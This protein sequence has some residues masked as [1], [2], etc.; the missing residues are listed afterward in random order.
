MRRYL[1]LLLAALIAIGLLLLS[2]GGGHP[3]PPYRTLPRPPL[4]ATEKAPPAGCGHTMGSCLPQPKSAP[5]QSSSA[6]S[7]VSLELVSAT[8]STVGPDLSN[9]NPVYGSAWKAI[10]RHSR[11]AYFKSVE[12]AG[13]YDPTAGPMA[14]SAKSAG[15]KTGGYDFLHVCLGSATG[16]AWHFVASLRAQHLLGGANLPPAADAEYP[17]SI[18]CSGRVW[19]QSWVDAV[20]KADG[21]ICPI[22][23]TGAWWWQPH[24]GSWWPTCLNR[25]LKSWISGYG[26]SYPYMPAGQSELDLWQLS[27]HGFNGYNYADLS[28]VHTGTLASLGG[29]AGKPKPDPYALFPA[30]RFS[31][32]HHVKASERNT[33]RT[34]DRARCR[35]PARRKVCKTSRYHLQLL[36]DRLFFVAHHKPPRWSYVKKGRWGDKRGAQFH[37]ISRR[38]NAR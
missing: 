13:F 32:A 28:V 19:I 29:H 20:Y 21:H 3:H 38:L 1:L 25:K 34:W 35:N 16:E 9:N 36:R 5:T 6:G 31:L 2:T 26:V 27:D 22:E 17:G 7:F 11:F 24:I 14:S 37:A 10:A 15:L 30:Q 8:S 18:G 12:G 4:P 23:Y 33:V